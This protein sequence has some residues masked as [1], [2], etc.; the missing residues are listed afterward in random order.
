TSTSPC[1]R[2]SALPAAER[3]SVTPPMRSTVKPRWNGTDV[4]VR[5][6]IDAEMSAEPLPDD[7]ERIVFLR[8]WRRI[9]MEK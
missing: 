1:S 4:A 6:S 2:M 7:C 9:T 8:R 5:M 3:Q